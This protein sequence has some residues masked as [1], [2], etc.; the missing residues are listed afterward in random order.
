VLLVF[1]FGLGY[2]V[3]MDRRSEGELIFIGDT[4]GTEQKVKERIFKK[5]EC[6]KIFTTSESLF[7]PSKVRVKG[8]FLY[9]FDFGDLKVKK[10]SFYGKFLE[11]YG[12]GK[13]QGPGE[14][15]NPT[16]FVV[17]DSLN[18]WVNDPYLM[19]IT[20]IG[21]DNSI[22][23]TFRPKN[24]SL[25]ICLAGGKV[26][27]VRAVPVECM[28]DVYSYNGDYLYCIGNNLFPEQSKLEFSLLFGG[29]IDCD[30]EF[31]YWA[32]DRLNYL[33]AINLK[34]GKLK[35]L[36]KTIDE[37][38]PPKIKVIDTKSGPIYKVEEDKEF[39]AL[40]MNLVGNEI[41]VTSGKNWQSRDSITYIDVY[42]SFDGRYLYSF[43]IPEKFNRGYFDGR[44]YYG[45]KD[46]VVSKWEVLFK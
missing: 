32:F 9:I 25:K 29:Y 5:V 38:T 35:Y 13:G 7:T 43:K 16:D 36:V 12:K 27:L 28:F 26:I 39:S 10:F 2:F 11:M 46:T 42:S 8:R 17:D 45:V 24:M 1:G 44:Y 34:D 40:S 18:I 19:S 37:I 41:F 15:L 30:S 23:R 4:Y 14:F 22:K 20:V 6:R 3:L 31:L 21:T 33:F